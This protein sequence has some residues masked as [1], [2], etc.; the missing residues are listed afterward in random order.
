MIIK[1]TVP[2]EP[3]GKARPRLGNSH[4]YTPAKTKNYERLVAF[5]CRSQNA[6]I[7]FAPGKA[8]TMD[9][10]AYMAVPKSDT[11]TKRERKLSG[12][13]RPT[14]KPDWD[15]IGKIISDALNGIAYHDDAQIVDVRVRKYYTLSPRVEVE[16]SEARK[17]E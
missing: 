15:N 13:M 12:I 6:N 16:I 7:S 3:Q 14:K 5:M 10:R 11:Q 4:T 1:I 9:I 17:H 2:G 8:L